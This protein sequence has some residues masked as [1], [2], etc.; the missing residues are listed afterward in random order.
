MK[1]FILN[2]MRKMGFSKISEKKSQISKNDDGKNP[3]K[4]EKIE[5][6]IGT[7]APKRRVKVEKKDKGLI[8]RTDNSTI[9][10][11]EDNKMVLTD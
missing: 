9:L 1:K 5:N 10:L 4:F 11:T 8:E 2:I 3:Q 6:I 7:K